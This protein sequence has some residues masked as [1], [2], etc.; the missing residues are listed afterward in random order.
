M[1]LVKLKARLDN[2]SVTKIYCP[3]TASSKKRIPK[4][5]S[6]MFGPQA[7]LRIQSRPLIIFTFCSR[8]F[9]AEAVKKIT[10]I[11]MLLV[12]SVGANEVGLE[13]KCFR[14]R[15]AYHFWNDII[16]FMQTAMRNILQIFAHQEIFSCKIQKKVITSTFKNTHKHTLPQI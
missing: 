11:N 6:T 3:A 4:R 15:K 10:C 13:K 16:L 1:H 2:K 8:H 9:Q 7:S 5:T 12:H 14:K